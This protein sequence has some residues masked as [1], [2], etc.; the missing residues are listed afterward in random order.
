M[1][2]LFFTL[3][4]S[5]LVLAGHGYDFRS[6]PSGESSG[7]DDGGGLSMTWIVLVLVLLVGT[8]LL[9]AWLNRREGSGD[10]TRATRVRMPSLRSAAPVAFIVVVVA[11][12]LI[13]WTASSGGEEEFDLKVERFTSVTGDPELLV[14]LGEDELNTLEATNGTRTVRVTCA[15]RQGQPV[16]D[17]KQKWPFIRE[18]G[19]DY[20]HAH[21]AA[22]E[23]QVQRA[24]RCRVSGTRVRLAADVK[25]S[26][27]G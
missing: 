7:G 19:Y 24:D 26:L 20:P 21:Q 12:P 17:A 5:S 3:L 11:A 1:Q 25:G 6:T 2:S 22:S 10:A 14:S 15:G 16:L 23:E 9:L 8:V 4:D 27:T 13:F 18:P